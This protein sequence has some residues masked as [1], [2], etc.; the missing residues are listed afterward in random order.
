M[1]TGPGDILDLIRHGRASTRGDVLEA[2]GLSR[3]TVAQ[4]LD[5]LLGAAMIVEGETD[6]GHRRATPA[7]PGLQHLAVP[8]P[9]RGRRHHPHP[10]RGHRPRR[11]PC[12]R[13]DHIEVP[14]EAGPSE[15][16]DRIAAALAVLMGKHDLTADG[17]CGV[18]L[19]L[20]GPG[21]PRVRSA[22]PAADPAGM[23]RLPGGRAPAGGAA[24]R[25]GADRERRRRGRPRRVRRRLLPRSGR[26]A[27]SRS[28]PASAPGSSSTDVPTPASTAGPATSAT[29]G[30]R[31]ARTRGASAACRAA[32]RP[33]PAGARWRRS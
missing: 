26:C 14:V 17:L 27:W 3:M 29:C 18:G 25:P 6:R 1:P 30:S 24:R 32:W 23:G 4:R 16:L 11:E 8:R 12:W 22:Q 13:E 2:T 31:R 19:S 5:A 10:D 7:Q 15:V 20:P 21:R 28:R 33:S 9:R